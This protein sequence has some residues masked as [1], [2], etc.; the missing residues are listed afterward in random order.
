MVQKFPG[1]FPQIPETVEFPNANHSTENSGFSGSKKN[2]LGMPC[3]VSLY[4][5]IYLVS[6]YPFL[7]LVLVSNIHD[8]GHKRDVHFYI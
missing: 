2:C 3:E 6:F 8:R 5:F 7:D 4:L 1:K